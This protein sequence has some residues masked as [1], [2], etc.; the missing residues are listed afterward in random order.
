MKGVHLLYQLQVILDDVYVRVT[1]AKSQK[2]STQLV[3]T[4]TPILWNH[5]FFF[6]VHIL[7]LLNEFLSRVEHIPL[8]IKN[9]ETTLW[10]RS[11]ATKIFKTKFVA[12]L[13]S[14]KLPAIKT[15]PKPSHFNQ[16]V[17]SIM[18]NPLMNPLKNPS[19]SL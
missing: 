6:C 1:P 8:K 15:T 12:K 7:N 19:K 4:M 5:W 17:K 18:I 11:L 9:L 3:L 2:W 16:K 13:A 14:I 10:S